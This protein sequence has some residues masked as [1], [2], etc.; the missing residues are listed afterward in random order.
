MRKASTITVRLPRPLKRRLESRAA[1]E[2]RSLS[3][4]VVADLEKATRE[5]NDEAPG[6]GPFLGLFAGSRLPTDEDMAEV[7]RLLWGRLGHDA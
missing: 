6:S 3:A 4:Q 2:H 1:S 5:G 7:R